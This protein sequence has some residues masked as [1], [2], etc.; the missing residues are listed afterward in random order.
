MYDREGKY[1]SSLLNK[2]VD[3]LLKVGHL[4]KNWIARLPNTREIIGLKQLLNFE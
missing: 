1:N 2:E 3:T 4:I